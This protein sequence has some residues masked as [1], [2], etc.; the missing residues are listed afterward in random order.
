MASLQVQPMA[1]NLGLWPSGGVCH[2][3]LQLS[4]PQGCTA[5]GQWHL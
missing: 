5:G 2:L 1:W 3:C 4:G